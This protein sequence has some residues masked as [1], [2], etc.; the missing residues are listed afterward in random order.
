MQIVS[1]IEIFQIFHDYSWR[2]GF[3]SYMCDFFLQ[4]AEMSKC[5][6]FENGMDGGGVYAMFSVVV[7]SDL[8]SLSLNFCKEKSPKHRLIYSIYWLSSCIKSHP[9]GRYH[10]RKRTS[11]TLCTFASYPLF[12]LSSLLNHFSY[13][14]K[15]LSVFFLM[16]IKYNRVGTICAFAF[17]MHDH[18]IL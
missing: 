14:R 5:R 17:I 12:T 10:T 11:L 18:S 1:K 4:N 6:S 8:W 7:A 2:E 13:H 16:S 9:N 3:L 15:D